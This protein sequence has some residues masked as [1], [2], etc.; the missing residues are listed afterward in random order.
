M[1]TNRY[2]YSANDPVN[3]S[4]RNGHSWLDRTW[5]KIFGE[6]SF[7]RTFGDKASA[8]SDRTFGDAADDFM[9]NSWEFGG[10]TESGL[11]YPEFTRKAF[12]GNG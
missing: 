8:W 5:D 7:N 12:Y 1:G 9:V 10:G 4:D 11:S 6:R 2:A 3:L